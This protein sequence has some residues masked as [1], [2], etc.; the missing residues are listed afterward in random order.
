MLTGQ[1][2]NKN[3]IIIIIIESHVPN[4]KT[5]RFPKNCA[6][7]VKRCPKVVRIFFSDFTAA[8]EP[9][10]SDDSFLRSKS[11]TVFVIPESFVGSSI[12]GFVF[13]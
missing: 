10:A 1:T 4:K 2:S 8:L 9:P 11:T 12:C 13:A 5:R 6:T 3:I 7:Y